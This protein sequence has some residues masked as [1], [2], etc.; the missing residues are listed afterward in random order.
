MRETSWL[1]LFVLLAGAAIMTSGLPAK[2]PAATVDCST[3]TLDGYRPGM[4]G[5]EILAVR[6]ATQHLQ[7][8]AQVVVP[9][10]FSG[11]IVV[12]SVNRLQKWDVKYEATDA[13]AIRA[14]MQKRFGAPTSDVTGNIIDD[15]TDTV[16]QRRTIWWSTAC[17][18][19]VIVYEDTALRGA[20]GHTVKATLA[21]ASTLT[22][23]IA[24]WTTLF[25]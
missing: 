25:K 7:E 1:R 18:A 22:P 11:V 13:D 19:A 9:G 15:A 8:Q 12:D 23:G 20:E 16:R 4:R 24:T 3:W 14:D 2:E 10:Q 21:R 17:D 5:P 6:P